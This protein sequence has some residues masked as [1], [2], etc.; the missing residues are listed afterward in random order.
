MIDLLELP[1]NTFPVAGL[2]IGHPENMSGKKPRLSLESFAHKER[3]NDEIVTKAVDDFDIE[4]AKYYE[5]RGDKSSNWS[6]QIAGFYQ[7][8]YFPLVYPTLK[9]QGFTL[10]K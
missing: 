3:Y 1:K 7:Q 5:K 8:V 4:I 2:V 9:S 10:D 6:D